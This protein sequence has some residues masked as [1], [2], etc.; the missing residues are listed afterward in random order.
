MVG[1]EW[2][3]RISYAHISSRCSQNLPSCVFMSVFRNLV[4]VALTN[5]NNNR[6]CTTLETPPAELIRLASIH[7]ASHAGTSLACET[8]RI[9]GF[10]GG[11]CDTLHARGDPLW[12]RNLAAAAVLRET[13]RHGQRAPTATQH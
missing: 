3:V 12:Q 13:D 8:M 11:K 6:P 1:E 7:S 2:P 9:E 4:V 5:V 10:L